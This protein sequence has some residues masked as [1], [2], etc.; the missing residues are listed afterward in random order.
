MKISSHKKSEDGSNSRFHDIDIHYG[1]IVHLKKPRMY[2]NG[3]LKL[4]Q[5][6]EAFM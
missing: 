5:I 2:T 4:S 1:V 3:I 6:L